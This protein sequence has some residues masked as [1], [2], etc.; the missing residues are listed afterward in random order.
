MTYREAGVDQDAADALIPIYA[1]LAAKTGSD[2]AG[3]FAGLLP[4]DEVLR[5]GYKRPALAAST[6][7]VGTKIDLLRRA[8]HHRTAGWD[9]VAMNVDDVV[10]SGAEPLLFVDCIATEHLDA[11]EAKEIV[12]GVAE[13]CIEAGCRLIGGE[14]AQL[15][16]LLTPG[17]Y[18]VM[19]A[20]IGVV[21]LDRAWGRHRVREG[22]A[23]VGLAASGLHSNGYSLV[24]HVLGDDA[25]PPDLLEPTAIYARKLLA[26]ADEVEVHAAAHITG[27]GIPGNAGRPL[28]K[29]LGARIDLSAWPRPEIYEW[30]SARGV[31]EDELRNTFNLGLGML[32]VTPDGPRAADVLGKL[33]VSS[34]VVG[35][36]TRGPG[37]ELT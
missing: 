6:D 25:P 1:E 31:S 7:T 35:A 20:C 22:D 5:R 16:G 13:G 14:T 18:E 26:L 12:T 37:V 29:D 34:W 32:V 17:A 36:V 2:D 23:I 21:D 28:P 11:E 33:G 9:C 19:G 27:G 15:P 30:L 3:G 24:R 4:L 10:C 8:G